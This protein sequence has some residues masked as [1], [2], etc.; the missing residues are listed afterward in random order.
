MARRANSRLRGAEN[1]AK[2][3]RMSFSP[4]TSRRVGSDKAAGKVFVPLFHAR[5]GQK[6]SSPHARTSCHDCYP[7]RSE[8]WVLMRVTLSVTEVGADCRP[9]DSEDE[10]CFVALRME[11]QNSNSRAQLL[12]PTNS[13]EKAKCTVELVLSKRQNAHTNSYPVNLHPHHSFVGRAQIEAEVVHHATSR[14]M[15]SSWSIGVLQTR[16]AHLHKHCARELPRNASHDH[17]LVCSKTA[18]EVGNQRIL[19]LSIQ[20]DTCKSSVNVNQVHLPRFVVNSCLRLH[21]GVSH[22]ML[23]PPKHYH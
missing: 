10:A 6:E 23:A 9:D 19:A 3:L 21:P 2:T 16:P 18:C 8:E 1:A 17:L 14:S 13:I 12:L 7:G 5:T 11:S 15:C 4:G 22:P 20:R